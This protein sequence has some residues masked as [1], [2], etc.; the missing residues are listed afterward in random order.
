MN[1]KREDEGIWK[2][3]GGDADKEG[4]KEEKRGYEG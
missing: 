4:I 2:K 3:E 1:H